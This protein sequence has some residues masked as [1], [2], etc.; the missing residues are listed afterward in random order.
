MPLT[1]ILQCRWLTTTTSEK[2]YFYVDKDVKLHY[3]NENGLNEMEK[4]V[5]TLFGAEMN[6]NAEKLKVYSNCM[7]KKC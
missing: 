4:I 3:I 1:R 5:L 7:L 6:P 2:L